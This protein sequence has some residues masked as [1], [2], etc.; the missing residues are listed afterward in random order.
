MVEPGISISDAQRVFAPGE[1]LFG[2]VEIP[3]E[4]AETCTSIEVSCLWYTIGKGEEDLGVLSFL[5][6]D[7]RKEVR[8]NECWRRDFEI[9]LPPSPVSYR[10]VIVSIVWCV[11]LRL[12]PEDA[13]PIVI[14]K[15][16]TLVGCQAPYLDLAARG[17]ISPPAAN[18][19]S[20]DA[21]KVDGL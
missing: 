8:S 10:G 11:R 20:A 16:F 1:T 14:E 2:R 9:Q 12:F 18:E 4:L 6:I 19:A 13:K 15:P 17:P 7:G 5:R 21:E 3:W